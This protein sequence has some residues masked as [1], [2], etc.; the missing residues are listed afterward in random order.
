MEADAPAVR[1]SAAPARAVEKRRSAHRPLAEAG[2]TS[3]KD[4]PPFVV[5]SSVVPVPVA[6]TAVVPVTG[7]IFAVEV[8]VAGTATGAHCDPPSTLRRKVGVDPAHIAHSVV[9]DAAATVAASGH[10]ALRF[11]KWPPEF[12]DAQSRALPPLAP[13]GTP[14]IQTDD[15][16]LVMLTVGAAEVKGR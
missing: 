8:S 9:D 6:S 5:R 10:G 1:S 15:P 13:L 2:V 7:A 16:E 4:L 11:T 14:A 12:D 3:L